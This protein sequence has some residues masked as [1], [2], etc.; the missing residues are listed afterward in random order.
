MFITVRFGD[1]EESLFNPNCRIEILLD[2][3]KRRC[4]CTKDATVDLSD[5][6]GNL[7]Y[8]GNHPLSY[9]SE[10]L[11][12]RESFVLIRVEKRDEAEGDYYTPLL[13]DMIT[14]TPEFLDRLSRC[15]NDS[16]SA[17]NSASKPV[18]ISSGSLQRKHMGL[19]GKSSSLVSVSARN[20]TSREKTPGQ[21]RN[22]E[23]R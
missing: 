10:L 11:K 20:K 6:A 4:N 14:I 13:N 5:E 16:L 2:A 3:I 22:K 15:E 23:S 18:R 12:A 8:L 19:K 21:K 1:C 17:K 7:K 9:A